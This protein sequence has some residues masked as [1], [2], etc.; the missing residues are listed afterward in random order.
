MA[1]AVASEAASDASSDEEVAQSDSWPAPEFHSDDEQRVQGGTVKY[2][3]PPVVV[4]QA[5]PDWWTAEWDQLEGTQSMD[6]YPIRSVCPKVFKDECLQDVSAFDQPGYQSHAD[7]ATGETILPA[8]GNELSG[9]VIG[10]IW[11]D[12][13][14]CESSYVRKGEP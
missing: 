6:G 8:D 11:S 5:K 1:S 9:G 3:L 4:P 13:T 7:S 14:L 10:V 2:F 12:N